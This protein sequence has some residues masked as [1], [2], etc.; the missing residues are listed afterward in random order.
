[1]SLLLDT[2]I[3]IGIERKDKELIKKLEAIV[4]TDSAPANISLITYFEFVHGLQ[5]KSPQNK[6]KSMAFIE[7][8]AFLEATKKTAVILSDLKYK[9][10][11]IGKPFPL[12]DLL[13]ASQA[14]ENN[15]TLI[16]SDK[17]FNEIEE[18]KKIIL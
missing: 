15:M 4:E 12:A 5:K 6:E 7:K 11:K 1:M 2:T 17:D 13:T 10:D 14:I 3:L 18:L 9:Y 16:T 8:F